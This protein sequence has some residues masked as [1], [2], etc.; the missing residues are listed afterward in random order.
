[1]TG[2]A[3][4]MA[5]RP[6]GL[7]A[8]AIAAAGCG[9]GGR[10]PLDGERSVPADEETP[11]HQACRLEARRDPSVRALDRQSN[12]NNE[13]NWLRVSQERNAA[14][15]AA[16]RACLRREGLALPGGVEPV[17]LR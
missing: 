17:R 3:R 8:L 7:L 10:L 5:W 15:V 16:Y 9:A 12:P 1:M 11:A 13:F 2:T 14:E 4:R 6:A